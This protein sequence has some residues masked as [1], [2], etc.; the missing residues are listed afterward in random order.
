[1]RKEGEMGA[2]NIFCISLFVNVPHTD[3]GYI[4]WENHT[5]E[6]EKNENYLFFDF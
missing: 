6:E 4:L 3:T 1:M 2:K 5:I